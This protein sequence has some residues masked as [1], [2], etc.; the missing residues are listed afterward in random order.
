MARAV[1]VDIGGTIWSDR[2]R[3][4]DEDV[5]LQVEQVAR[6]IKGGSLSEAARLHGALVEFETVQDQS[7]YQYIEADFLSLAQRIEVELLPNR[8]LSRAMC[9]P[10]IGRT[11]LLP[12]ALEFLGVVMD[13]GAKIVALTNAIWR[14]SA[15]YRRDFDDFGILAYFDDVLSSVDYRMRKPCPA[16]FE[17]ACRAADVTPSDAM[18]L[19]NSLT[20]DVLPARSLGMAAVHLNT[21]PTFSTGVSV[22]SSLGECTREFESWNEAE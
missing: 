5:A 9:L 11:A 8:S 10:A 7:L 12:G 3:A 4:N 21:E 1:I 2:W 16:F 17:L 19:G 15:A 18:M 14:S 6:C 22:A 13:C 20:K